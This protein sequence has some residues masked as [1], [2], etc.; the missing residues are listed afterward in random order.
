MC[1]A[2]DVE[3]D[4]DVDAFLAGDLYL[5][6]RTVRQFDF[7]GVVSELAR[8]AIDTLLAHVADLL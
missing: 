5:L 2:Y 3:S 4:A 6:A 8:E 7:L 1:E